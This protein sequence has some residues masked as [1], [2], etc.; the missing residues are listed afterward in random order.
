MVVDGDGQLF[1]G[2][3]LPDHVL[4]QERFHF[5]R[6]RKLIRSSG[7]RSCGPVIFQDGVADRN[8]FI[9]NI[10]PWIVAGRRDQLGD[11][12]LRFVAERIAQNLFGTRSVFHSALL[13]NFPT[14]AAS[15]DVAS[16]ESQRNRPAR[17]ADHTLISSYR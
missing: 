11:C 2:L 4:V 7:S 3:L 14:T 6:F 5:Q 9:A 13:L 8:A 10:S 1:L 16:L 15:A 17:K 12:V